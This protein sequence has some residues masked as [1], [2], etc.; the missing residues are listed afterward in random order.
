MTHP[1]VE[2]YPD[3]GDPHITL[4][5]ITDLEQQREGRAFVDPY[6][7]MPADA[8]IPRALRQY[9]GLSRPCMQGNMAQHLRC[10]AGTRNSCICLCHAENRSLD[11][12]E[13]EELLTES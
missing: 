13:I 8:I 5:Q 11:A 1:L 9:A 10:L 3:Y 7:D 4:D 6:E 12:G 2:E